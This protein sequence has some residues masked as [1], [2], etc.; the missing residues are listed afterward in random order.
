MW[1]AGPSRTCQ[2]RLPKTALLTQSAVQGSCG[3][4]A[5]QRTS[6]PLETHLYLVRIHLPCPLKGPRCCSVVHHL[7]VGTSHLTQHPASAVLV[8]LK[9]TEGL[10]GLLQQSE[11]VALTPLKPLFAGDFLVRVQRSDAS[12]VHKLE[13]FG[14][15]KGQWHWQT[16]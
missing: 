13:H 8:G 15:T 11:G 14:G 1:A 10:N 3:P 7:K 12:V 9:P 2:A 4:T 16:P 5:P 6:S